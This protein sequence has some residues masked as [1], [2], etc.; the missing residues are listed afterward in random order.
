MSVDTP[1]QPTDCPPPPKK[2]ADQPNPP[3][4]GSLC[5]PVDA[6]KPQKPPH[7]AQCPETEC[8]CPPKPTSRSNCLEDLIEKQKA[9]IATAEKAAEFKKQ[10]ETFLGKA[11]LA[12][13]KY[14]RDKYDSLAK[15]WVEVDRD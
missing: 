4:D 8:K 2:P 6:T 3:G 9:D 1:R 5:K 11:K 15:K 13:G 10:L 14:T 12:S 7:P